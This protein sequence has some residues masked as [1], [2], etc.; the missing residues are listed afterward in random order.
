MYKIIFSNRFKKD[1]AKA[2]KRNLPVEDLFAVVKLLAAGEPLPPKYKDHPLIGNYTGYRE[3]HLKPDWL[4][5]YT[6]DEVCLQLI[7][8]RTGTHADLF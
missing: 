5:I 6:R 8:I 7:L 1:V 2:E 4:L 3:C